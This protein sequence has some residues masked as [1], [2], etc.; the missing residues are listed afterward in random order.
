M[1]CKERTSLV[2]QMLR[3]LPVTWEPPVQSLGQEDPLE[4]EMA[5]Q[6]STLAL[7]GKSNGWR[8][9]AGYRPWGCKESDTTWVTSLCKEIW[10]I[11]IY[12]FVVRIIICFLGTSLV[13]Q[14]L[15]LHASA[16]GGM[17]LI[18]CQGTKIPY[19]CA[20]M[21]KKKNIYIYISI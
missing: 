1:F 7:P 5:T 19:P 17:D 12:Y 13:V 4:K 14:W 18:A 9:L 21:Q 15:T 6:S 16:A 2:A 8:I 10:Y 20:A 11:W 3:S